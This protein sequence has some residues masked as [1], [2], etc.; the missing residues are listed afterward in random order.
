MRD[1]L[2]ALKQDY[3]VVFVTHTLRQAR[4]LADY[5]IFLY[6]GEL[7]EHGP[8]ETIFAEPNDPT[9][10]AYI[11]RVR[12]DRVAIVG[13]NGSHAPR[14]LVGRMACESYISRRSGRP[15]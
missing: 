8:T 4:R 11:E 9:T 14:S 6:L 1:G 2:F 10:K 13:C 5:V 3:T 12:K 15:R 7:I